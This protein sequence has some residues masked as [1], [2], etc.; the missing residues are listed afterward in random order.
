MRYMK[1]F[2]EKIGIS[3]NSLTEL[4]WSHDAKF[5]LLDSTAGKALNVWETLRENHDKSGY[6]PIIIGDALEE[7]EWLK[8][9]DDTCISVSAPNTQ[10][11]MALTDLT[12]DLSEQLAKLHSTTSK[13]LESLERQMTKP[14]ETMA[15]MIAAAATADAET[16]TTIYSE[17]MGPAEAI[18]KGELFD[19]ESWLEHRNAQSSLEEIL[20]TEPSFEHEPTECIGVLEAEPETPC[21]LLLVKSLESWH[22]P[23]HLAFGAWNECPPSYV[24]VAALKRWNAAQAAEIVS[25]TRDS[26]Y[27]RV[28]NPVESFDLAMA[29]AEEHYAYCPDLVHQSD[30]SL[31]GL[32]QE[33]LGASIWSFW[34]N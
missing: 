33:I 25:I 23:A 10:S 29:L 26:F 24:H 22:V 12:K 5:L 34:W 2:L 13:S 18:A 16:I 17:T 6:W 3:P 11:L 1:R 32:A 28:Q 8:P 9:A 14:R 4:D 19:F 30:G 31:K 15:T 20:Q 21:S 27:T 7:L